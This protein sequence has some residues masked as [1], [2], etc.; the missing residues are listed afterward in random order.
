MRNKMTKKETKAW[1]IV[2][3]Y[4]SGTIKAYEIHTT[5]LKAKNSPLLKKSRFYKVEAIFFHY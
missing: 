5:Y 2:V 3:M 1:A 4:S